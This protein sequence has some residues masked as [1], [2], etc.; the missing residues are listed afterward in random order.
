M[1]LT[2]ARGPFSN[3]HSPVSFPLTSSIIPTWKHLSHSL[4]LNNPGLLASEHQTLENSPEN[5][6]LLKP[7][8]L[9]WTQWQ[10]LGGGNPW[11][12]FWKASWRR[13]SLINCKYDQERF[14]IFSCQSPKEKTK[15]TGLRGQEMAQSLKTK[16]HNWK[17]KK[18]KLGLYDLEASQFWLPGLKQKR[19]RILWCQGADCLALLAG[20]RNYYEASSGVA[21]AFQ[22]GMARYFQQAFSIASQLAQGQRYE[23]SQ[24]QPQVT[25]GNFSPFHGDGHQREDG[26]R[27]RHALHQAAHLA[28]GLVKRPTCND[29]GPHRAKDANPTKCRSC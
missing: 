8:I 17:D 16:T 2:D 1:A 18:K 4:T 14:Y 20:S 23:L 10:S 21:S 13:W 3:V 7:L 22:K 25:Q 24:C 27:H 9:L 5:R 29:R 26:C 12:S 19:G 6:W 15:Q 11:G 28:C